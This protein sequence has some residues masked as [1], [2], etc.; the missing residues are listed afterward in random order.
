MWPAASYSPLLSYKIRAQSHIAC[1]MFSISKTY[2]DP[3]IAVGFKQ[4]LWENDSPLFFWFANLLSTCLRRTW[5]VKR[6]GLSF[7]LWLLEFSSISVFYRLSLEN[8]VPVWV[9]GPTEP[10]GAGT[11]PSIIPTPS[12]FLPSQPQPV[13][14]YYIWNTLLYHECVAPFLLENSLFSCGLSGNKGL[15]LWIINL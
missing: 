2:K 12:L 4:D 9:L 5:N 3:Q 11:A 8:M 15:Y 1:K 14:L 10:K 6:R 13:C 7:M